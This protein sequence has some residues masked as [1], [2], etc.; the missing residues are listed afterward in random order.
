MPER[1]PVTPLDSF[2][3]PGLIQ[4]G[5]P[6]NYFA[7]ATPPTSNRVMIPAW[8]ILMPTPS[9]LPYRTRPFV[10]FAGTSVDWALQ[11]MAIVF[12]GTP[13]PSRTSP[14]VA[15]TRYAS[16]DH[17]ARIRRRGNPYL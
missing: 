2:Q 3:V 4:P 17:Q 12:S 6:A 11:F 13:T 16:M 10:S 14:V 8:T 5:A 15:A 7:T 1:R 9:P